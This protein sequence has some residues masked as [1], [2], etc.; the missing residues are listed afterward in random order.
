MNILL[1]GG[2]GFVGSRLTEHLKTGGHKLF[3]LTRSPD[4]HEN[5]ASVTY[6]S[7][8]ITAQDLPAIDAVINLAGESIFGYWSK[9]KKQAIKESR[10][11][12]TEK[13]LDLVRTM[14][15]KPAVWV[16]GSAVGYYG[17]SREKIFTEETT[18][19]GDDFLAH[20][21]SVWEKTASQ[22]EKLGIRTVYTRFGVILGDGG[23]LSMMKLPVKYFAGG[24]IGDGEQW[25]SWVH[26]DDVVELITFC[27]HNNAISGPINA[28][29]PNPKQNDIFMKLVARTLH[30]PHWLPAPG[31]MIRTALGEM[32]QLIVRGQYVLPQKAQFNGYHFRYT[33]AETALKSILEKE[34]EK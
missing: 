21:S 33:D 4:H 13:V 10:I 32:S 34:A 20:V 1:T 17:M 11:S 8:D 24:K 23:A 18:T 16:N 2:T 29:A 28:T 25:L 3:I 6:V 19:P 26:I 31:F 22:A 9:A 27:L 14:D 15:Q 30:R 7:Y 12:I 5:E